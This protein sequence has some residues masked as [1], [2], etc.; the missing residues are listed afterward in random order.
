MS[1]SIVSLFSFS[2]SGSS[3]GIRMRNGRL[4]G[5]SSSGCLGRDCTG[6]DVL[7]G[8]LSSSIYSQKG[9][10]PLFSDLSVQCIGVSAPLRDHWILMQSINYSEPQ[11][12]NPFQLFIL[13]Q[14]HTRNS[15]STITIHF[16]QKFAKL[17]RFVSFIVNPL[18]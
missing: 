9:I 11:M 17:R 14:L 7:E 6:V 1:S 10:F 15:C 13:V 8:T 5:P 12:F 16:P 2:A 18:N 3:C 4:G